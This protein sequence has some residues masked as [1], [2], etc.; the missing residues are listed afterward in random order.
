MG[1]VPVQILN[2]YQ[3]QVSIGMSL[4]GFIFFI[5]KRHFRTFSL[6]REERRLKVTQKEKRSIC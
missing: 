2:S 1:S 4:L 5:I 6:L 3:W